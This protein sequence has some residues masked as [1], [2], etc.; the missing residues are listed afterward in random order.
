[1][2]KGV[3]V[4]KGRPGAS[5]AGNGA[6]ADQFKRYTALFRDR[7]P[8]W[9]AFADARVPGYRR[10]QMRVIGSGASGKQDPNTIP[11]DHFT[12]SIMYVPVG[13][14]NAPHTH[15]VEEVFFV[16]K[17]QVTVFWEDGQGRRL[18]AVLGPWDCVSCPAGVI[19]GYQN[20]GL[21]PVYM[22]VMLGKAK[23]QL[24]GYTDAELRRKRDIHLRKPRA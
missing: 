2:A 9:D 1:M 22:Q 4:A 24:M 21:E 7:K 20:T 5:P 14:G 12:L 13:E 11:A 10:A 23:P 17:G 18:E 3:E 8:D 15:E 6:R 19:H 16:L